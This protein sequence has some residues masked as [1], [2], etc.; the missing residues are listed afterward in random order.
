MNKADYG[1]IS[2][3]YDDARTLS[4]EN[5]SMWLRLISEKAPR[6]Q[7]KLLDL[8][9]GTGRFAIPFAT[10]L[11]YS[12]TVV[13]ASEQMIAKARAKGG[14]SRV[15][16]V[17]ADVTELAFSGSAFDIVFMSHLLH[18]IDQPY[19]LV[20]R[21]C[22]FLSLGGILINRYGAMEHIAGDPEHRFFP[23][24]REIDEVRTPTINTVEAW[25]GRAGL[26]N[27][28]SYTAVQRTDA[29]AEDRVRRAATRVSSVLSLLKDDEFETGLEEMKRYAETN[30]NDPW[31]LT[32]KLTLTWGTSP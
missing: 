18:H 11:G 3:R 22:S 6:R 1:D 25:F 30:G 31:M 24:T 15:N 9:C 17:V 8:G 5:M 20:L 10:E 19:D 27:I 4:E 21:C 13:D 14:A 2:K 7:A 32:D 29:N 26:T 28:G 12:V 16:W 23:R